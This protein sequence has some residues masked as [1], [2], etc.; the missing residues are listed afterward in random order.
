MEKIIWNNSYSVGNEKIDYQHKQ[1][2]KMINTL[3]DDYIHLD[4]SSD[5]LHDL[6][7][8]MTTYFR[9]HFNEEEKFLEEIGYP[10]IEKHKK[11]H[12]HYIDKTVDFNFDVMAK[13]DN[14]SNDM[15]KF[16]IHWW[17]NHIL[18]EDMKFKEFLSNAK[19]ELTKFRG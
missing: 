13:K 6:L 4:A 16:L 1:I 10:E 19:D 3:L 7:N 8:S 18:I 15:M 17:E 12:F 2:I 5:Q 14:I 9:N 11:L